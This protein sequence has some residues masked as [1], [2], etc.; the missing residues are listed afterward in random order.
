MKKA[1]LEFA[2]RGGT[3]IDEA[4]NQKACPAEGTSLKKV[5]KEEI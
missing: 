2:F 1:E 5:C 3:G 4:K